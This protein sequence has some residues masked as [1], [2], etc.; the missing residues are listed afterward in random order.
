MK[1]R[2]DFVTNSSSSSFVAV[3]VELKDGTVKRNEYEVGEIGFGDSLYDQ[4]E[5]TVLELLTGHN[6]VGE[7]INQLDEF[8]NGETCCM[9]DDMLDEIDFADTSK[10]TVSEKMEIDMEEVGTVLAEYSANSWNI[11]RVDAYEEYYC[12]EEE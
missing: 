7:L 8:Y 9:A 11:Q 1:I 10:V 6:T 12:D 5:E 3:T 2:T 4:T